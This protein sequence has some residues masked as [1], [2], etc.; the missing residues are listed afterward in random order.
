MKDDSRFLFVAG[1]VMVAAMIAALLMIPRANPV[2]ICYQV[3]SLIF[4]SYIIYVYFD[5]CAERCL[6]NRSLFEYAD[7]YKYVIRYVLPLL[8]LNLIAAVLLEGLRYSAIVITVI[9]SAIAAIISY[10]IMSPYLG[11]KISNDSPDKNDIL[12]LFLIIILGLGLRAYV[13]GWREIP[14]GNDAPIYLL[15]ALKGLEMPINDLIR[16]GLSVTSNPY[17]DTW[18]FSQL[19]LTLSLM[20]LKEVGLGPEYISKA[21]MPLISALSISGIYLVGKSIFS[22]RLGLYAAL[23]FALLPTEVLFAQ[24]YKEI[25]GE[26]FLIFSLAFFIKLVAS[27]DCSEKKRALYI[28][29]LLVSVVF[30]AKAAVTSFTFFMFF[31]ISL[32]IFAILKSNKISISI[33]AFLVALGSIGATVALLL[34][35]STLSGTSPVVNDLSYLGINGGWRIHPYGYFALPIMI[36]TNIIPSII[37]LFYIY[38]VVRR[39]HIETVEANAL[40]FSLPIL[41]VIM[42]ISLV[43]T[44][45]M[46]YN[47]F[48]TSLF[49]YSI[50]LSIY[51]GI[52]FSII[53]AAFMIRVMKNRNSQMTFILIILALL[54]NFYICTSPG[55]TI[56]TSMLSTPIDEKSYQLL[57][58]MKGPYAVFVAGNFSADQYGMNGTCVGYKHWI[59]YMVYKNTGQDPIYIGPHPTISGEMGKVIEYKNNTLVEVR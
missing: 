1:S 38:K 45:I 52:P 14:I 37:A 47:L 36:L 55:T 12:K 46:G 44:S 25:F 8:T 34:L 19:S 33:M 20:A 16:N 39:D 22:N 10:I 30:L 53:T 51:A 29:L 41:I 5:T 28:I 57:E 24:L 4:I 32:S 27:E 48:P 42:L 18:Q 56:H 50:R 15:Q 9:A 26:F 3:I 6:E 59:D 7:L 23:I 21:V 54:I 43:L 13:M 40:A 11:R 49:Y 2:F 17:G 58:T 31:V 35:H